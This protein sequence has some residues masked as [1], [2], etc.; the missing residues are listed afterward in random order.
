MA[1]WVKAAAKDCPVRRWRDLKTVLLNAR[2][3]SSRRLTV[4]L[5]ELPR[6]RRVPAVRHEK[7]HEWIYVVRGSGSARLDRRSVPLKAGDYLYLPPKVWHSFS[8]GRTGL[9]A[10]SV[11]GPA[12]HWKRPD[13]RVGK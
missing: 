11:Y 13:V 3:A 12:F 6:N 1:R 10:V 5:V 7:T 2:D 9:S 8:S 4:T